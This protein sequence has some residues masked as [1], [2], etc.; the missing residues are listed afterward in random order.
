[1]KLQSKVIAIL[2]VLLVR[3]A[4]VGVLWR[5]LPI[6]D[7]QQRSLGVNLLGKLAWLCFPILWLL[8]T[9]RKLADYG[10]HFHHWR[11]DLNAVL[12]A[13]LPVA[14]VSGT[15]GFVPYLRWYGALLEGVLHMAALVF[16]ARALT[17][18]P[19]PQSGLVTIGLAC[20][21]FGGYTWW[22]GLYPGPVQGTWNFIN[23]LV[24][25]GFAEEIWYRGYIQTRLNQVFEP[26]WTFYGVQWGWGVIIASV[27]FGVT[28][29]LNGWNM[30]TGAFQPLWWW[31]LWTTVSGL[32]YGYVREKTGSIVA[33][34]ILHGLPQALVYFFVEW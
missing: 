20:V 24:F 1:M 34:S 22:K 15:L 7:W 25:V 29:V 4:M 26:R 31:G 13:F 18:E 23:Y 9:R 27:I 2:E 17:R 11:A 3:T 10:I 16:V 28:H 12:S 14:V 33:G 19:D 30:R 6:A 32:V 21:M 8:I 5:L